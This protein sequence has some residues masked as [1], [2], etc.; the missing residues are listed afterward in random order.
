LLADH[1]RPLNK[2]GKQDAPRVGQFLQEHGLVP[3]RIISS[4]AKR[5]RKTAQAVAKASGYDGKVKLTAAFFHAGPAAYIATLRDVSDDYRRVMVVGH[6]PGL[7]ELVAEVTGLAE[8]MPTAAVAHISLPIE[9][10][11]DLADGV[12]G[13]LV[14]LWRPKELAQ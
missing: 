11:K 6:N 5:A 4:T 3:D 7:E 14:N 9:Q 8:L 1:D 2:R 10:W 13:E 12:K